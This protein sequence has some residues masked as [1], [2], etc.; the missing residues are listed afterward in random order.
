MK[1]K[2]FRVLI[3]A[4]VLFNFFLFGCG[5]G[6]SGGGNSVSPPTAPVNVKATPGNG[7]IALDWDD[8][9]NASSYNIYWA[10]SAGVTRNTGTKQ[11]ATASF[12]LH[13]GLIN[14]TTY[15][16]VVTAVNT[17]GESPE[18]SEVFAAPMLTPPPPPQ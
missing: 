5:G 6:G 8:V 13:T 15:Y 4:S 12:Y 17:A 7:Q 9:G 18:S 1:G 14:G 11:T 10:T 2:I 3:A 16:Y